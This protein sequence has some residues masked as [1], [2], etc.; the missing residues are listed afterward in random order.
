VLVNEGWLFGIVRQFASL[1]EKG[2][3]GVLP[4]FEAEQARQWLARSG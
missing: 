2:G 1:A 4:F 3:I